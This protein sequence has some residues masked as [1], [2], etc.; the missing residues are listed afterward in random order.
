MCFATDIGHGTDLH[1]IPSPS[2]VCRT[3]T[4][5]TETLGTWWDGMSN[6]SDVLAGYWLTL[7]VVV[8]SSAILVRI[9]IKREELCNGY[10]C[11]LSW[12]YLF[13]KLFILRLRQIHM[14]L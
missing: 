3:S 12:K 14:Q 10:G 11:R 6:R 8:T 4:Q 9:V 13:L 5:G 7:Q 1:P 2:R